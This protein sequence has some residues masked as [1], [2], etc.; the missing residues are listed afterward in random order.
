MKKQ[1]KVY[2]LD[3]NKEV[4]EFFLDNTKQQ[5]HCHIIPILATEDNIPLPQGTIDLIFM[6]NVHHH[7]SNRVEYVK[8]LKEI[9]R[10][11]KREIPKL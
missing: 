2:S 3:T 11:S 7:I 8:R 9:S 10:E 1:G 6:H 5:K 4:L